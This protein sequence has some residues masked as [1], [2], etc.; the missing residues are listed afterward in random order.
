MSAAIE[1]ENLTKSYGTHRAISNINLEVREGDVF[2]YLG[3]NGA[4]KTTTIRTL[5]DLIRPSSGRASVFGLDTRAHSRVIK[6][7]LAYLPGDIML[8]EKLTGLE[9]LSAI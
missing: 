2:G 3:P 9:V 7:S 4:G 8:Y 1:T 5:L 6:R